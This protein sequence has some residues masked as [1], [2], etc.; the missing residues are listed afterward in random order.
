MTIYE[1]FAANLLRWEPAVRQELTARLSSAYDRELVRQ[2]FEKLI[3]E[4]KCK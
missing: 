1:R 2:A 4:D 3:K